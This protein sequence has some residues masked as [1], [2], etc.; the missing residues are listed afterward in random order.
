MRH[1]ENPKLSLK[2]KYE[3]L[4]RQIAWVFCVQM[5]MGRKKKKCTSL[6]QRQRYEDNVKRFKKKFV[7]VVS[8]IYKKAQKVQILNEVALRQVVRKGV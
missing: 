5:R 2:K 6:C 7:R 4:H 1:T 8:E 3:R